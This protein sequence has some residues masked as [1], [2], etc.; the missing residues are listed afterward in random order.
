M[1]SEDSKRSPYHPVPLEVVAKGQ[2]PTS[3]ISLIPLL[4]DILSNLFV[5]S[6]LV[7]VAIE[8][9]QRV[10][11]DYAAYQLARL[12]WGRKDRVKFVLGGPFHLSSPDASRI[13]FGFPSP[14]TPGGTR[15]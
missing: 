14:P 3:E 7:E 2:E 8:A 12:A 10:L 11:L 13:L 1:F 4:K 5:V 9:A 15:G 6:T